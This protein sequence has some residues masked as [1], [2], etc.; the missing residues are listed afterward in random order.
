MSAQYSYQG[1]GDITTVQCYN[2][3]MSNI[4]IPGSTAPEVNQFIDLSSEHAHA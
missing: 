2:C 1:G 3:A 4:V